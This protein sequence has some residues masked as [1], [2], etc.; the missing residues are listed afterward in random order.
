M[1]KNAPQKFFESDVK[2]RTTNYELQ[3]TNVGWEF[4]RRVFFCFCVLILSANYAFAQIAFQPDFEFLANKIKTG[5]TEQKRDALFAI[6][7]LES[8]EASRIAIPALADKQEIV[9]ATAAFSVIF[10]P[11][12]EAARDLLPLLNDKKELVRREAAYALGKTRSPLAVGALIQKFQNEKSGEV[13]NACVTALGALGDVSA[14]SFLTQILQKKL[15]K[16]DDANE[17]M[18]RSAA[19]SIGQ[20]AQIIQTANARVYTPENLLIKSPFAFPVT[21]SYVNLVNNF[22]TFRA[23]AFA[24]LQ[25]LQNP[26]EAADT[27]RES[28]FAL[29]AIGDAA[30]IPTLQKNLAAEDYYLAQICRESLAKISLAMY[31]QNKPIQ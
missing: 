4:L 3:I 26:K 31:L 22:P 25:I 30:A 21:P 5:T 7:N 2:K 23:A 10:L 18:R 11:P 14:I 27:K 8:P 20:I 15:K 13:K 29:G 16:D 28:A 12:D 24:L 19:R 1:G 17:F 9:R 6:R